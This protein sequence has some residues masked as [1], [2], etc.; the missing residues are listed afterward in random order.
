MP[1]HRRNRREGAFEQ[2]RAIAMSLR[3]LAFSIVLVLPIFFTAIEAG[4]LDLAEAR[5]AGAIVAEALELGEKGDW[6]GAEAVAT[7]SS[8]LVVRDI[9]LWRKL[10]A[11]DGSV[12][13]YQSFIAR[14]GAWPGQ[15]SLA[16]AVFGERAQSGPDGPV[17]AAAANWKHFGKLWRRD[18]MDEAAALLTAI[19]PDRHKLG[20][21]TLWAKRRAALA[22]RAARSG[23]TQQGYSLASQH[24]LE[25]TDGYDYS[26]LEWLAGWIALRKLG[27]PVQALAHF[28]RFYRSVETPISLGRGGY[29]LGRTYEAM[30]D[31]ANASEWYRTAAKHQ[32]SFYGQLAA[33]NLGM[34]GDP[35]IVAGGLPDWS[36]SPAM[37]SDDVRAAVVLHYAGEDELAVAMF[38]ELGKRMKGAAELAV[39]AGL[40]LEL[41]RPHYAVKVAKQAARRGIM[42]YAAYYPVTELA[43]YARMVEPGLAMAI[44]RQE[45]ELDQRAI[46]PSGA[47][48]LMQL[49]PATAKKVAG[50]IGEAY[51]GDR[52]L[53]DW[54][55]NARLGQTYLAEQITAFSGSY[56]LAAAAYNAGPS[57][58][59]QWVREYG[60]PRL[61]GTD[62]IDWIETIPF[63]E[64]R[65]YVQRVIE[66]LWV[67]RARMAGVAGPMTIKQDLARGVRG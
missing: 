18:K 57:R 8:D 40:A 60:D 30:G 2:E 31:P 12:A 29:W 26:D 39:L 41:G 47:R 6:A 44:A 65:N 28:Q 46:S 61:P 45:T 66:A 10:R 5:A 53:D 27:K 20:V 37:R 58:V 62:M 24:H 38:S 59:N 51:S 33:V 3:S 15:E 16:M 42:I 64:T 34:A 55:Y 7:R 67:Y 19:S 25:S 43:G 9:V 22:R 21:P 11:S 1:A 63:D 4:A 35:Q 14:R 13:E 54:Q 50:G 17:G 32:S 36:K 56:V 52:L 23:W 49:M 48:G